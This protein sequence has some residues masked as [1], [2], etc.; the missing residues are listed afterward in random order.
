[1]DVILHP[2]AESLRNDHH[3]DLA[4]P[5]T[6]LKPWYSPYRRAVLNTFLTVTC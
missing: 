2:I 5:L 1:M 3:L 4:F 6:Y